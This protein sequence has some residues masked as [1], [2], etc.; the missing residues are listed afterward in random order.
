[1]CLCVRV[2]VRERERERE[3]SDCKQIIRVKQKEGSEHFKPKVA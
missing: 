1:M 2:C 3:I